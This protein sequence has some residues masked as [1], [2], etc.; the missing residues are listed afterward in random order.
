MTGRRS[1]RSPTFSHFEKNSKNQVF[2]RNKVV[3]DSGGKGTSIDLH[4]VGWGLVGQV[5]V[6]LFCFKWID[7]I[8]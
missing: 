5:Y 3:Q 6:F 2:D 1:F 8:I 7:L 4:I